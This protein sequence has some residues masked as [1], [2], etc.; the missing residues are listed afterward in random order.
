MIRSALIMESNNSIGAT[1]AALNKYLGAL[2]DVQLGT[3]QE[4][5]E[6]PDY[7][8]DSDQSEKQQ[9]DTSTTQTKKTFTIDL[10]DLREQQRT[11]EIDDRLILDKIQ[12]TI[13]EYNY[14]LTSQLEEQ[15]TYFER[16]LEARRV[17]LAANSIHEQLDT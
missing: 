2:P 13:R 8:S 14:L 12:S 4:R 15:R 6:V 5:I 10:P 16:K 11:T 3:L 7:A 9:I 1:Q 17:E